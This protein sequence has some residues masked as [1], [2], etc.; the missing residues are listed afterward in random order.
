MILTGFTRRRPALVTTWL[1]AAC[2]PMAFPRMR[3]AEAGSTPAGPVTERVVDLDAADGRIERM[4]Y[5]SPA[6]PR[7]TLVMLPGGTGK[8]GIDRDG[9]IA[10]RDNFVVRTPL[11]WTARGYAVLIPDAVGGADPRGV[12][13]S[14]AYG[15]L[16]GRMVDCARR[17]ASLP[18]VLLGTSQGTIAAANGA[19]SVAHDA[20]PAAL[21]ALVRGPTL[22]VATPD[23]AC[24]GA[25]PLAAGRIA[26]AFTTAPRVDVATVSGGIRRSDQACGSRSP[27]GHDGIAGRVVD[28]ID[29]WFSGLGSTGLAAP[30]ASR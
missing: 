28:L 6:H 4:L 16:V 15:V 30:H 24:D 2:G 13:S 29:T 8:V 11:P 23:D 18:V 5:L 25:P 9:V 12:R 14:Q 20:D 22:S 27:H 1:L 19:A 26:A 7:A 17:L 10:H 3:T 21:A